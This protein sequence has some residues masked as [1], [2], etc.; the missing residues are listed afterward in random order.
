MKIETIIAEIAWLEHLYSLPDT[1]SLV[2]TDLRTV[3][4]RHDQ[5]YAKNSWLTLWRLTLCISDLNVRACHPKHV[6]ESVLQIPT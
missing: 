6:Q 1:R 3:N 2:A 5:M 4:Q